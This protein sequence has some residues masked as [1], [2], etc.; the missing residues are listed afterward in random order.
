MLQKDKKLATQEA[1]V[2]RRNEAA[3]ERKRRELQHM[4][5]QFQKESLDENISEEEN[6]EQSEESYDEEP[7]PKKR[8]FRK[9]KS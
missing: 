3:L 1:R 8:R 7:V 6:K 4:K 9:R 5:L 2:A